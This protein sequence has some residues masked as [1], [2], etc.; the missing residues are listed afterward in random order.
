MKIE[1][2]SELFKTLRDG[3]P[4]EVTVTLD[5]KTAGWLI[6]H[7]ISEY[8]SPSELIEGILENVRDGDP[9]EVLPQYKEA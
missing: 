6:K 4:V 8:T 9:H 5:A 2:I 3:G 1:Q 7:A